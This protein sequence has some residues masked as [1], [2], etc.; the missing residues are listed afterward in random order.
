M[1][2]ADLAGLGRNL[3]KQSMTS[4]AESILRESLSI[5]EKATPEDWSRYSTMSLLGETLLAKGSMPRPSRWSS[6]AAR[7]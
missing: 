3:M 5:S 1:L 4:E 7:R 2:A 6:A